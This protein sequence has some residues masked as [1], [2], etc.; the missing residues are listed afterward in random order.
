MAQ[1]PLL[2]KDYLELDPNS[3]SCNSFASFPRNPA[4]STTIRFLL[5]AERCR[6]LDIRS[7]AAT[8]TRSPSKSGGGAFTKISAAINN[9]VKN[10]PLSSPTRPRPRPS[11]N[12]DGDSSRLLSRNFSKKLTKKFWKKKEKEEHKVTVKDIVR[13]NSFELC[14]ES[15]SLYYPSPV[16]SS[17]SSTCCSDGDEERSESFLSLSSSS[18][19]SI[20]SSR[21]RRSQDRCSDG[22]EERSESFLLLSSSSSNSINSSGLCRSQDRQRSP[23][24][25]FFALVSQQQFHEFIHYFNCLFDKIRES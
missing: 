1:K 18:S 10:F 2:L 12:G 25:S 20:N 5:E 23:A 22:D 11:R 15:K 8:P 6:A 16:V 21:L 19:N 24:V 3:D 17:R 4:S 9:A 7:S 14:G 13:S